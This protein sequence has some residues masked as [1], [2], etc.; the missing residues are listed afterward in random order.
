MRIGS[1]SFSIAMPSETSQD[2]DEVIQPAVLGATRAVESA[3][4]VG[5][6]RI[7]VTSSVTAVPFVYHSYLT[8]SSK[9]F[10]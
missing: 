7:I 3:H 5:I 6:N 2:R 8:F 10:R 4:D 1:H 9:A